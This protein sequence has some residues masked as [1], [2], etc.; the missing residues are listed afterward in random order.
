MLGTQKP[1]SVAIGQPL[2]V[3]MKLYVINTLTRTI[4][5]HSPAQCPH[6]KSVNLIMLTT[7]SYLLKEN[8][9]TFT[10]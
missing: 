5:K 2:L 4:P 6:Q 9:A 8:Y 3:T 1:L 10:W 7:E